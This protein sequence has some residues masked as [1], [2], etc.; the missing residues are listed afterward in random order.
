MCVLVHACVMV[1]L[2]KLVVH[3]LSGLCVLCVCVVYCFYVVMVLIRLVIN[4]FSIT[5]VLTPCAG[6]DLKFYNTKHIRFELHCMC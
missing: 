1:V 2:I 6:V 5:P 3:V 4:L